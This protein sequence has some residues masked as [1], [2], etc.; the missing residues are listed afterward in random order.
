MLY[1][2]YAMA[3]IQIILSFS[4]ATS[5][6]SVTLGQ[7]GFYGHIDIGDAPTPLLIYP[8]PIVIRPVPMAVPLAPIYLRVPH[9]HERHWHKHCYRYN[10]CGRPV[11]FVQDHWYNNVYVPYYRE[12]AAYRAPRY[13][14]EHDDDRARV[15]YR[16]HV[17]YY[18]HNDNRDWGHDRGRH[19]GHGGGWGHPGRGWEQ[20][21]RGWEQRGNGW[22]NHGHGRGHG[23]D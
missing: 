1:V 7:P 6:V 23:K 21:G 8:E 14:R 22:G 9:G 16:E 12:R 3:I 17:R 20:Q 4:S 11:Y 18:K 19:Y 15:R 5:A 10:A 2:F 13:Y